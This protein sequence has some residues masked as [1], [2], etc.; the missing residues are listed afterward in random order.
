M[1]KRGGGFICYI[2]DGLKF[3]DTSY[4][5]LKKSCNDVEMLWV[6]LEVNNMRPVVVVSI[7]RPPQ[8]DYTKCIRYIEEAFDQ[9]NLKDNTDIF[10]LGDFNI[11]FSDKRDMKKKE[12][13]F[14]A[15]S[16]G[17]TQ[18]IK[19]STRSALRNGVLS[20]TTLDLIFTNLEHIYS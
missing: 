19:G 1:P 9:A 20:E 3:S 2:K 5:Q 8:G 11:D 12:L 18:K 10:L 6:R 4:A 15:R 17:L 13:D 16:L 14:M 7:Y